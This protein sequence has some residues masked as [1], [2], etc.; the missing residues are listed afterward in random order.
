MP[1]TR[2]SRRTHGLWALAALLVSLLLLE[3]HRV[4][5][6]LPEIERVIQGFGPWAPLIFVAAIFVAQPFLFPNTVF[7]IAG[8]VLFGLLPGF[9]YY[10]VGVYLANLFVYFL[11]HRWLRGPVVRLLQSRPSVARAVEA[12]GREGTSLVFWIRMAPVSPAIF[13]YAF[14][15]LQVPFCAVAIGTLGMFPHLLLDVYLGTVAAHVTKMAGKGDSSW[16]TQGA[17]LLLGFLAVAGL[18]FRIARIARARVLAAEDEP[19]QP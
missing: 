6:L 2:T 18:S 12:A 4:Q 3:G 5:Q 15:A 9:A 16:E 7:G 8:G 11:G 17:V 14:G 1:R 10:F 13:S 19:G